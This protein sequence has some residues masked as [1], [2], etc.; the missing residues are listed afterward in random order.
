MS[1]RFHNKWHRK[2][3]HTYGNASNPDA[4][5]DP[6][7]S[8]DQP[9]M[10]EFSLQGALCC[11]APMSSYSGY[12]YSNF[13]ALCAYSG[14]Y[15]AIQ[16]KSTGPI[17][18]QVDSRS[19]AISAY[20]PNIG[21]NVYSLKSAISA[22]GVGRGA[23][24][25]SDIKGVE[26]TAGSIAVEAYSPNKALSANGGLMGAEIYSQKRAIS[27]V[28][29][30]VGVEV[31]SP[32]VALCATS[33]ELA[34]AAYSYQRAISAFSTKIGMDIYSQELG[35][36]SFSNIRAISAFGSK[37]GIDSTSS[38]TGISTYGTTRG[39]SAYGS[40]AGIETYSPTM[41]LCAT[42]PAL[43]IATYSN[44]TAL[45]AYGSNIA[46]EAHSPNFGIKT[47]SNLRALSAYG[48]LIGLESN[49]PNLGIST[50]SNNTGLS[51]YGTIAGIETYSL[52]VG[53]SAFGS[54][55]GIST[56]SPNIGFL[57][58]SDKV[59]I[60]VKSNSTAISAYAK[61]VALEAISDF[62][63]IRSYANSKAISA[64]GSFVGLEV[65]SPNCA[66][67]A[68][69]PV[70]AIDITGYSRFNGDVTITGNLSTYGSLTYLDTY[71]SIT[72]ALR[73][74]NQGTGP[75]LWARQTGTQ[76][77]AEFYDGE[78]SEA[79]LLVADGGNVGIGVTNPQ[80]RLHIAHID[81]T[82]DVELR[83]HS[84]N[85]FY[86]PI[87]NLAGESA[88]DGFTITYDNQVGDTYFRNI[89][90]NPTNGRA[91]N[92]ETASNQNALTILNNGF[93][94][95]NTKLPT[96][97]FT[98]NGTISSNGGFSLNSQQKLKFG[99]EAGVSDWASIWFDSITPDYGR[100]IIETEDNLDEPIVFRQK[101]GNTAYDRM[102]ICRGRGY[103]AIG[104]QIPTNYTNVPA[105]L[106]VYGVTSSYYINVGDKLY[107]GS[108]NI[109]DVNLYRSNPNILKTDDAFISS[110]LT[111]NGNTDITGTSVNINST[112]TNNTVNIG[113][114]T[115]GTTNL[116]GPINI[117]TA[118]SGNTNIGNSIGNIRFDGNVGIGMTAQQV[119][120]VN[121]N[122]LATGTLTQGSDQKLKTNIE[123]IS[124]AL[125]IVN[126]LRGVRYNRKD[127]GE[128]NI[129]LIAQE[130]EKILPEVVYGEETKSLSYANIVSVLIEA[131][132]E[133][134]NKV[135]DLENKLQQ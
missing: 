74:E 33:P 34:I 73:V 106:S 108:G 61:N 54:Q 4:S 18:I 60:A 41:A 26:A 87:L 43:G 47:Y 69:S 31:Y 14:S 1:N 16:A 52:G 113:N 91:F 3:H 64:Y 118:G 135:K 99:G 7:A 10:G 90:A 86:N 25:G 50:F 111:V 85:Y 131:I 11:V 36:S 126:Q 112:G 93:V 104:T 121:G 71:V 84:R 37:I 39:L 92:F 119:L 62:V 105:D 65:A 56:S 6:I 75:A 133:L 57:A 117:N 49:S 5:H 129:G 46:I 97:N 110:G 125:E 103:I 128:T 40:L 78:K 44:D 67:S 89:F 22:Y 17:G 38:E 15:R 48:S 55:I 27:A 70:K 81:N 134:N 82:R 29:A 123:T 51:S 98:V 132:K 12:F 23:F 9:F 130:V 114:T 100:L 13:T 94:G 120:T 102:A 35:I 109:P 66:I 80:A 72:S 28:G 96:T 24:I 115:G 21:L 45:S 127:N 116:Y 79:A 8:Q 32:N 58:D 107:F 124:N 95:V 30:M 77:I 101:D 63:G 42:S 53:L 2:N 59:G 68:F 122:I 19:I 88:N 83:I 76:N 20:A